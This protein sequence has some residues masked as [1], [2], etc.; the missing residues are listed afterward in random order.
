[1]ATYVNDLR[2]KEIATGDEAGT[3]GTSTNT[4]LELIGNA[5]GFGT[6]AITT[7]ADTHASTVADGS[8]DAARA[9]YIKYTGTLDS[10]C[11]ITIGPNTMKRV[12]FIENGTSGSQNIIISQGSG[13]NITIPPG[14]TKAVYL[15][16][17]GSGAAVVDAFASLNV[18]DLKVQDDLTVTDDVAIGGLATVGGTLGVTGIVTL[19][20]DLIIGDGK[21]IG[22]ASD[23]DAMTIAANGQV[24]FSQT[25]IGT[26]LDISGDID[27]DGTTNLDIVDIDGAVDMASTLAVAGVVTANAGVVVDNFTLDGTTLALSSGD[28]TIDSEAAIV[29][30][31]NGGDV[32]FKDGGTS[33]GA[34][35]NNGSDFVFRSLVSDK[36][37]L[38][39]GLDGSSIITALTLDMSAAGSAIFNSA[40]TTGSDLI[41]PAA[42]ILYLDGAANTYITEVAA[43]NI[44]FVVGGA[45]RFRIAP[46]AVTV[47][48]TITSTV[49]DNSANLT[50]ISTDADANT[51]PVLDMWRNSANPADGDAIGEIN[52]YG[53]NDAGEQ[54][55]FANMIGTMVDVS[56]GTEDSGLFIQNIVAGTLRERISM[57]ATE[58]IINNGSID[59]DFRVESD[60]N[61]NMLFV[62]GGNNRVGMGTAAPATE[63]H[64][65]ATSGEAELR[66]EAVAGSESRLRF[67]DANDNDAGYVGYSKANGNL[68]FS[69]LNT[70]GEHM[71]INADGKVGI[72]NTT[73]TKGQLVVSGAVATNE[74]CLLSFDD[75]GTRG[76]GTAQRIDF[77]MGRTGQVTDNPASIVCITEGDG[78]STASH[79]NSLEFRTVGANTINNNHFKLNAGGAKIQFMTDEV[80]QSNNPITSV[81]FVI[82]PSASGA[83]TQGLTDACV[84]QN[85]SGELFAIDSS[86]NNTQITPHNWG[87]ISA[88]ASE[89][90]A[91]TYYSQRPNPSDNDQLQTINVDM[92]KVIRKVEDLVGEKLIYTENSNKDSHSFKNIIADIQTAL[93]N[94]TT[95]ITNLEG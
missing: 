95:R 88:G 1:M 91:W 29:L 92:A 68:N 83:V 41:V 84:L 42:G 63:L 38:I 23:V 14:D 22:S 24:T 15:D 31:A 54:I 27:V 5:L 79:F 6:E 44:Q 81:C 61:A 71:R 85:R 2:L 16:G 26:A 58:T 66:L 51:G 34:I 65:K 77:R 3:W 47:A 60:G 19:T 73:P 9:M 56:D 8:A 30:D 72:N 59:L 87:L 40:V 43:D 33:I 18:V 7:N 57:L 80:P 28:L 35:I 50:L 20:D 90:L 52:Y 10:A 4:N 46:G 49:A 37:V 70:D 82:G 75:F 67:G 25:L 76:T 55:K 62:D 64:I 48:G 12:H 21:T 78:A 13:A 11:T 39:K 32:Q 86:H 53:E 36:D 93:T 94:L 45:E 69:A 89:E 74:T 17:A